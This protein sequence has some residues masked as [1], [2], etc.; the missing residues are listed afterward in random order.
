MNDSVFV[1]QPDGRYFQY[2]V[3]SSGYWSFTNTGAPPTSEAHIVDTAPTGLAT[4]EGNSFNDL[5]GKTQEILD[6]NAQDAADQSTWA[7]QF[8]GLTQDEIKAKFKDMGNKLNREL[9]QMFRVTDTNWGAESI[10]YQDFIDPA[11]GQPRDLNKV[12][13]LLKDKMPGIDTPEE[14]QALRKKIELTAPKFTGASEGIQRDYEKDIY[15]IQQGARGVGGTMGGMYGGTGTSLRA[16]RQAMQ[17]ISTAFESAGETRDYRTKQEYEEGIGKW[18]GT[19]K[20]D[21][22]EWF[23]PPIAKKGGKVPTFLEILSKLPDAGGS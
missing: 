14:E 11:T 18:L 9:G 12:Y 19:F 22:A 1:K 5:T 6:Q 17:D 23:A 4:Q 3:N 21:Q 15:G 2:S 10:G 13:H 16:G 7:Q 8:S 20:G